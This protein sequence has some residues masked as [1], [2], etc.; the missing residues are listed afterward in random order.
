[1]KR[2]LSC[3]KEYQK[4][5]EV[6][7]HCGYIE[8]TP[9][10]EIYHLYPGTVLRERFIIGTVVGF[11]GFGVVYKAWDVVLDKM[12]AIKEFYP[13]GLIHRTPGKTKVNVFESK[14]EEFDLQK[15]RFL[16]EAKNMA[17]FSSHPNIINV[18]NFFEEN[19]TAYIDMEFLEGMTYKKFLKM[20]GG[21][22]EQDVAVKV[23]LSVLEALREIHK[24]NIIHR[25]VA[26]DNI[27]ICEDGRIK[28]MDFGAARFSKGDEV[29]SH[30]IILKPGF[31]P[32]EQYQSKSRQG[33]FTDIYAVGAVLYR[34][35]TGIMPDESTNR[36]EEDNM[37]P[38][39]ELNPDITDTMNNVIL[40][41]MALMYELRF[42]S[43]EE[44]MKALRPE[45]EGKIRDVKSELRHRKKKR[46]FA[47]MLIVAFLSICGLMGYRMYDLKKA[48]VDL[49]A[50]DI[51]MWV[52]VPEETLFSDYTATYQTA[53]SE[54]EEKYPQIEIEI[55]PVL[56]AE[57]E[58][59]LNAA[60]E[61]NEMPDVF[62]LTDKEQF[63]YAKNIKRTFSYTD[64]A[65][66][67]GYEQLE[68]TYPDNNVCP[69]TFELP[70]L[71]TNTTF[72]RLAIDAYEKEYQSINDTGIQDKNPETIEAFLKGESGYF[73]GDT[74]LYRE[75]Q[76]RLAG[77]YT[78]EVMKLPEYM[79]EYGISFCVAKD[80]NRWEYNAAIQLLY[81][82][83]SEN[84]QFVMIEN[85][86]GL[87]VHKDIYNRFVQLN[88]EFGIFE[89][90]VTKVQFINRK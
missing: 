43:D 79:A 72:E 8:G 9:P 89:D 70:A 52:C 37:K 27:F 21:I 41:A 88:P 56:A 7:P 51:T 26:P 73:V 63:S 42:Q 31:A 23:I 39:K 83:L 29:S 19:N 66:Y 69:V 28:L 16:E 40:R 68:E 32:P 80:T 18:Y 4:Q 81:Y 58:E 10:N 67:M 12:V 55:V 15:E 49:K 47:A 59:K 50:A 54:Y 77:I 14:K 87:P 45:A 82:M 71:Y 65:Q 34:S 44:F 33:V 53:L 17:R 74:S 6:C 22:V 35:L 75:V 90:I 84:A 24:E 64:I 2:C 60:Y 20:H 3:M 25:D 13:V 62:Q 85:H 5:Y 86:L 76:E 46:L 30:T 11:G 61:N 38:P 57:Y 1:M 48:Q 78:M 36:C